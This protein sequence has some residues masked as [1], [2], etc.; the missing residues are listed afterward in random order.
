[1]QPSLIS[2]NRVTVYRLKYS[3]WYVEHKE[4]DTQ[5][6]DELRICSSHMI[7]ESSGTVVHFAFSDE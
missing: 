3:A 5:W 7:S 6:A 1:M 4:Q 2:Q